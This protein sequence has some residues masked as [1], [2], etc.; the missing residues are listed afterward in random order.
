MV[1]FLN[2]S[3]HISESSQQ[4]NKKMRTEENSPELGVTL[5]DKQL[6]KWGLFSLE[7]EISRNRS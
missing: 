5:E 2:W 1:Y 7:R 6:E 3:D 4:R